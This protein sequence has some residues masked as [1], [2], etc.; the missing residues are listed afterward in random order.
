MNKT[1]HILALTAFIYT[2]CKKD[3]DLTAPRLFRPVA[4]SALTADSN[5]IV[6]SWQQIAGA[7]AYKIEVSRDTFRT[8]DMSISMDSNTAIIKKLLFNQLYQLQVKAVAQDTTMDSKWSYLGAVKTLSSIFKF[9]GI[10]DITQS[11][12]KARWITRGAPVTSIKVVKTADNSVVATIPL[13]A[14]DQTNEFMIIDGLD[15]STQYTMYLYSD[16]DERGYVSFATKAPFTGAIIDLT[17]ITG[18]PGVLTD[19]LPKVPSGSTILLKRGETY[20]ISSTTS[21][22]KTLTI[23]SVPDLT[24]PVQAKLYFTSNFNFAAG[25]TIDYIEFN[26]LHMYSDNYGGRYVFNNGNNANIGKLLFTNSRIEIFRGMCRLQGG[27]VNINEFVIN[28]CIVDSIKDYSVLNINATSRI[29]NVSM[30]NST[31]YKVDAVI[32]SASGGNS[33]TISDCTFNEAPLGNNK[34][35]YFSYGSNAL[36]NGFNITNCIFGVG[37]ISSGEPKVRDILVGSGTVI[38]LSN[39][40]KTEDHITGGDAFPVITAYNRKSVDIWQAPYSGDFK[41]ADQSFPGRNSAGDPRWR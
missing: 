14:T 27:V 20:T 31:F 35:F 40:Y 5:T 9:P 12:V 6:A 28:N 39:N 29:E 22:N 8:I 36:T 17:G 11:S 24:N 25:A 26:D 41:I 4:A 32:A 23:S 7:T 21:L 13:S 10:S 37:K 34:N 33:V 18:R 38:G 15:A 30:L 1:F 3:K 19:T 2:S 16:N